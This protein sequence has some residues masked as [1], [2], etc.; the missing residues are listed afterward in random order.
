MEKN[1]TVE[2]FKEK[3]RTP[4]FLF[5][6]F[7]KTNAETG[8]VEVQYY[9]DAEGKVRTFTDAEGNVKPIPRV[10]VKDTAN[11]IVAFCS[12]AVA[13]RKAK[14]MSAL[15]GSYFEPRPQADGTTTYQLRRRGTS[16]EWDLGEE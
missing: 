3:C 16:E 13:E 15:E 12:A 14:G 4:K 8:E 9:H 1:F 6:I 10:A 5:T 11:N 2:E 7:R